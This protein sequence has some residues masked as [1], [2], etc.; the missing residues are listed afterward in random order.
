MNKELTPLDKLIALEQETRKYG[1]DWPDEHMVLD[2]IVSES[3]EVR[4]A[5]ELGETQERIREEVG[6]L[7]HGV[8]SLCVFCN[9]DVDEIL[10]DVTKKFARRMSLV[11]EAALKRG[12][13]DLQGQS[14]DFMLELWR[15]AK[16]LEKA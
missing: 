3:Q 5:I 4:Q 9:Y 12:L 11:R 2:Q 6:D 14:M 10:T 13:A 7:L 8:V 15:E 1:F 16:S